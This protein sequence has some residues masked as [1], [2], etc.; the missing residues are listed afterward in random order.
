MTQENRQILVMK[1]MGYVQSYV[2]HPKI[3]VVMPVYNTKEKYLR[4]SVSS[5]LSQSC[6]DFE[7]LVI[8]DCSD[9]CIAGIIKSYADNRIKYF[10]LD[11][12]CGAAKARNY[13]IERATGEF[14]AFLDSD[15]ISLPDRLE[16]QL[17]FFR[18]NPDVSCLGTA[19]K[20]IDKQKKLVTYNPNSERIV[21]ELL[22]KGCVL[23]QSSIMLR[24]K[25]LERKELRYDSYYVPAEDYAFFL[26]LIGHA[27][28]ALLPYVLTLYRRHSLSVS[29]TQHELQVRK[30]VL[31]QVNA[32]EKHCNLAFDNKKLWHR[33]FSESDLTRADLEELSNSFPMLLN[34][35]IACGFQ[36]VTLMEIFRNKLKKH[37]HKTRTFHGQ[38]T[39]LH[40]NLGDF[41]NIPFCWRLFYFVTRGIL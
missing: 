33:F 2:T 6:K 23:C 25:L 38:W 34:S 16:K 32:I 30:S 31:A 17:D 1:D 28:F 11:K 12:R 41:F 5:I 26:T 22:F 9:I 29:H 10:R 7:L 8:D 35:L 3:S 13:A 39:L 14:I 20:V 19:V 24:R 21:S 18:K 37:Y 27:R 40:S 4:E 36:K 15:D